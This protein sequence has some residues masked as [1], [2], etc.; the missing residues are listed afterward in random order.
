MASQY[1]DENYV[2][3]VLPPGLCSAKAC[4]ISFQ[5][6]S[7]YNE[8]SNFSARYLY[9]NID[10][11]KAKGIKIAHLNKGPGFL[12]TKLND[13][14]NAISSFKPHILGVSEANLMHDHDENDIQLSD[15]S[16]VKCPTILNA[17]LKYS[18]VV[19]YIQN[20]M[21]CKLN[22]DLPVRLA[23]YESTLGFLAKS[24]FLCAILTENDRK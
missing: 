24:R 17:S 16:L 1:K 5:Q 3:Y 21:V 8:L 22:N 18:R 23:L 15:Y 4:R 10:N 2:K 13:I 19:V 9:S 20:S 6:V 12:K 14:E 7:I 11:K